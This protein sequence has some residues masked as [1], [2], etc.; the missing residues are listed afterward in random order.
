M[1]SRSP[2]H[3]HTP[4]SERES[5]RATASGP[6]TVSSD[7]WQLNTTP[8]SQSSF[9]HSLCERWGRARSINAVS[10]RSAMCSIYDTY[11]H[12][13]AKCSRQPR[14][15]CHGRALWPSI[16][17]PSMASF[18]ALCPLVIAELL[19]HTCDQLAQLDRGHRD[20]RPA[21]HW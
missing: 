1:S 10:S 14:A 12:A 9:T 18:S 15:L 6:L 16:A 13:R 3:M 4:T 7:T 21:S 2:T 20:S 19:R 11:T 8:G 5:Q 17:Y